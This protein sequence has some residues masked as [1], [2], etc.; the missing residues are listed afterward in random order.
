[1][2][3]RDVEILMMDKCTKKEAEDHLKKGATIFE[4][5]EEKFEEYMDEWGIEG[6]ERKEYEKMISDKIPLTDWGIVE[7]SG[8]KFYI[9]Y[10]L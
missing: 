5:F 9:M 4:D 1:M 6:D 10:M 8:K 7:D 2:M 3:T